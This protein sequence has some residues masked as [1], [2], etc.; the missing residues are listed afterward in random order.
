M[1]VVDGIVVSIALPTITRFLDVNV[2][3]LQWIV[4]AYM[5]IETSL[6]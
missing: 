3:Q 4:T 2:T 5:V 6:L 1:G